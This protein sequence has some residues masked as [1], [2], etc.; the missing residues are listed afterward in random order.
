MKFLSLLF[1]FLLLAGCGSSTQSPTVTTAPP[2]ILTVFSPNDS[3]DGFVQTEV[4][5]DTVTPEV[6]VE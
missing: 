1:C 4:S 5:V 2:V 6:I 3:A